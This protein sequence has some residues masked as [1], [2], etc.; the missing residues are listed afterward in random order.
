M[1]TITAQNEENV[2]RKQ[3]LYDPKAACVLVCS[4]D[5]ALRVLQYVVYHQQK[6]TRA[7]TLT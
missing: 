4:S 2:S 3:H 7:S 6:S 5:D 1:C